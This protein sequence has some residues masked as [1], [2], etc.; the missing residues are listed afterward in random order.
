MIME[1]CVYSSSSSSSSSGID[2]I[3]TAGSGQ[4]ASGQPRKACERTGTCMIIAMMNQQQRRWGRVRYR[5]SHIYTEVMVK[6]R[7]RCRQY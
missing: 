1:Y 5:I 7:Y 4:T 2:R 6:E 3:S